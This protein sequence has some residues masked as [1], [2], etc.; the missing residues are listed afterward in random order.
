MSGYI[1]KGQPVAV[2]D[3]SVEIDDF[4][5]TGTASSTTFLRG[6]NSWTTVD[7]DLVSD[8]TPKLGGN[9]DTNG[10]TLD[11]VN[12]EAYSDIT[13]ITGNAVDIFIY[14]TSKDSDGG[15]WRKRTQDTSWYNEAASTT[16]GSRKDFPAVAVIVLEYDSK[17]TI[18]DGDTPDLDMWMVFSARNA[19][20][21]SDQTTTYNY[22]ASGPY[23]SKTISAVNGILVNAQYRNAGH[24]NGLVKGVTLFKMIE[25]ASYMTTGE[26]EFKRNGN[27]GD[28][29]NSVTNYSLV[30]AVN[31]LLTNDNC[32]DVAMTVLPNAPIDSA[33][34]LPTPTIAVAT[35]GGVSVIKDDGTVA[36]NTYSSYKANKIT[37]VGDDLWV[38]K[39]DDWYRIWEISNFAS[40]TG[41]VTTAT[42]YDASSQANPYLFIPYTS[43]SA[44]YIR[45]SDTTK[46]GTGVAFGFDDNGEGLSLFTENSTPTKGSVAYITS[47]YNTGYMTGD[48]RGAWNVDTDVTTL[49]TELVTNGTFGSGTGWSAGGNWSISSGVAQ[50]TSGSGASFLQQAVA[51]SVLVAGKQYSVTATVSTTSGSLQPRIANSSYGSSFPNGTSTQLMTAGSTTSETVLFYANSW[52]GTLDNVSVKEAVPDRSVKGNGLAV[53]GTPTV[54]AVATGAELKCISGFS[55]TAGYT[56]NGTRL[57]Q[58]YNS[59][60]DFTGDWEISGW[61][62]GAA[63]SDFTI[64]WT[65]SSGDNGWMMYHNA[66]TS[67]FIDG[68][69]DAYSSYMQTNTTSTLK[70]RWVKFSYVCKSGT[71]QYYLDGQAVTNSTNTKDI[72][73]WTLTNTSSHQLYVYAGN[74]AHKISLFRI[75]AT[76]PTAEQIKE[77]YEAE[78]PLFQENAKC[79]LDGTSDSVT[80][81]DY[82]DSNDELLVGTATNLS[83]F[84]G[85]RRVDE[86]TNNIT[87]VAQ[88]GGLRVE[89]Y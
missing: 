19:S 56:A 50:I 7:T 89:E 63:T 46:T 13:S 41:T 80:A 17:I 55:T 67:Y 85:L 88:Q 51:P 81:M 71:L 45:P 54:S 5:A 75:S 84:K 31:Q 22:Y 82:D 83:V 61:I 44:A 58:P 11:M 79:T 66:S 53:H 57:Q 3:G 4:S 87:E 43:G 77:I 20:G 21:G 47:K 37:I 25:D 65:D 74:T 26:G 69:W 49:G 18:Y 8:T 73:S 32:N 28:T 70:S 33:T 72:S 23:E 6:D 16:R 39:V 59:D 24:I 15:A 12:L 10:K 60:L 30:S 68:N 86:N 2:E 14:D 48:I 52:I 9:L 76:A 42:N 29:R 27:L 38:T 1:G 78:K 64:A 35:D 34:G 36:H 62:N 40:M